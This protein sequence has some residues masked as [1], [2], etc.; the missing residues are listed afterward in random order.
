[1]STAQAAPTVR[2]AVSLGTW[3][4]NPCGLIRDWVLADQGFGWSN[5]GRAHQAD[6]EPACGWAAES[7]DKSPV[8][9]D[10]VAYADRSPLVEA[11]RADLPG[12]KPLG[13]VDANLPLAYFEERSGVCSV[14]VG[15]SQNQGIKVTFTG[16]RPLEGETPQ[17]RCAVGYS[18]TLAAVGVIRSP[19]VIPP[20]A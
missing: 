20:P 4:K 14:V 2:A 19:D 1:M 7:A 18:A 12:F 5:Q 8:S 15:L 3:W 17:T 9:L 10:V 11:Y 6:G 13:R 16:S